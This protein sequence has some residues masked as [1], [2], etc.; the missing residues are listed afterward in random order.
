MRST[1]YGKEFKEIVGGII[2][3]GEK[4][5]HLTTVDRYS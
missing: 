5:M 4:S 2:F 3:F 1:L